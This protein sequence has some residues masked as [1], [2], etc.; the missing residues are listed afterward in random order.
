MRREATENNG[1]EYSVDVRVQGGSYPGGS[2][3]I[4]WWAKS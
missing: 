1:M 4:A 2:D 3:W